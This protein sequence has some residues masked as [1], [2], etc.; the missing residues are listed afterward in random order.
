MAHDG[1]FLSNGHSIC[2]RKLGGPRFKVDG[3]EGGVFGIFLG[4][5]NETLG[6]G[7]AAAAGVGEHGESVV[8]GIGEEG[9][10]VNKEGVRR[11]VGDLAQADAAEG[12]DVL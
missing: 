12:D 3:F 2:F 9:L 7:D 1:G 10:A 8:G 5:M 11:K 6:V 4:F